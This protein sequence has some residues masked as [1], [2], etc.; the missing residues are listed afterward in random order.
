MKSQIQFKGEPGRMNARITNVPGFG[1]DIF[2]LNFPE[3][4]GPTN[5]RQIHTT[6][7][8]SWE[9]LATGLWKQTGRVE[10]M[11]QYT[12]DV[13]VHEDYV[14]FVQRLTNQGQEVWEQTM[15]FNC[16]N[17][18]SAISVRDHECK[19]HWV[20]TGSEFKKLIEIPRVFGPRPALQLYNVEGAPPGRDIP[21]VARFQSTPENV[22]MEGWMSI[23]ARDDRHMVA[24]VSK[25][26]LYTFQ[27]REYSCIHSAPT[28][29]ALA[30]G[31]TG[32]A[33][34]RVYFVEASL[35]DWYERMTAEF[36]GIDPKA[37]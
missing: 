11:L 1:N 16:F 32:K 12:I 28:F 17:N 33:L 31:E 2:S 26:A 37:Y 14:D 5:N 19:R 27:N 15:A 20:R 4:I 18:G 7:K 3:A 35:E 25:K 21:F 10:G 29:G 23:R 36:A 22:T 13:S 9:E 24:T 6:V 30:P 8:C 34:T